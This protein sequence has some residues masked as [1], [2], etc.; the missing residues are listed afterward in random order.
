MGNKEK[1]AW[2]TATC[3]TLSMSKCR[4]LCIFSWSG[5]KNNQAALG[6]IG[7]LLDVTS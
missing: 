4:Y 6:A 3:N 2:R 7:A 1:D 5:I